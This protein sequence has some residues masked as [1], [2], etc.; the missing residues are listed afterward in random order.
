MGFDLFGGGDGGSDEEPPEEEVGSRLCPSDFE[1]T[2]V[3]FLARPSIVLIGEVPCP[4]L[5]KAR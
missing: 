2:A 1:G 3:N 4:R 5:P